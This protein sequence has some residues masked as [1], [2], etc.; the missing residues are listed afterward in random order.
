MKLKDAVKQMISCV[1]LTQRELSAEL[2]SGN[3]ANISVP[4]S[5]NSMKVETL[6]KW[7]NQCGY[8]L[9]LQPAGCAVDGQIIIGDGA[10]PR[11][12]IEFQIALEGKIKQAQEAMQK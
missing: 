12:Q 4:L 9:V 11:S 5:R 6:I 8:D 7:A 3:V 1:G 10:K 2:Y